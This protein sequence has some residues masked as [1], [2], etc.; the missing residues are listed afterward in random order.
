MILCMVILGGMG[1]IKGVVIGG[2][3]LQLLTASS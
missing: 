1:N 3:L 2:M